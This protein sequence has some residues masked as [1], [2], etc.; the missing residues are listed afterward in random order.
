MPE[1]ATKPEPIAVLRPRLP[2]AESL[3]PLLQEI[4]A[5]GIYSNGGPLLQRFQ[6]SLGTWLGRRA[7]GANVHVVPASS[8]TTAIE[9]ALRARAAP[10]RGI[11]LMPA[12]TFVASAHA[13][14]NAG[15]QPWLLDV[16]ESSLALTP[17]MVIEALPRLPEAP[18]AVLVVSAFGAPV[19]VGAWEAFEAEQGIPVVYDAAA[20][21]TS[22][23]SIGRQPLCVSLH[24]TKVFGIGEGG[25]LITSDA[26][27][28]ERAEAMTGF[29][30]AGNNRLSVVRGG[31]YRMSEY[32]AAVGLA[33]LGEIEGKLA[34]ISELGRR[35]RRALAESPCQLQPGAASDWATMTL[36]AIV[37]DE[38]I[39]TVLSRLDEDRIQ[40]RRWWGMGV[41]THPAFSGLRRTSL[42]T[43]ERVARQ[44]IGLPFFEGLAD[45]S[46]ARV[47]RCLL[48]PSATRS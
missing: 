31:N 38:L 30:F 1:A 7:G 14:C 11:C 3:L 20:A 27:L 16:E 42:A 34:A 46:I 18:A 47:A 45:S 39:A 21:V 28:A 2:K 4:D 19:D 29:G 37:P 32:A 26:D 6:S 24:A 13:V 12:F 35:Y 40:W 10:G 36:N 25:A 23:R 48:A 22:L 15:L 41:H 9:V 43:T 17:G 8:G 5:T 33:V 44:V